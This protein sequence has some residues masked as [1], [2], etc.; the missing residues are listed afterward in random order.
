M[1]I[2]ER[3]VGESVVGAPQAPAYRT[4]ITPITIPANGGYNLSDSADFT[5]LSAG[6]NGGVSFTFD[7]HDILVLK[8]QTAST[9]VYTIG[10]PRNTAVTDVGGS[11]LSPTISVAAGKTHVVQLSEV[12]KRSDD[13]VYVD[14]TVAAQVLVFGIT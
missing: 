1:P 8:N 14:C 5:T 10:I 11:I 9:A 4:P 3:P 6:P 13:K 7:K 12:A 2:G